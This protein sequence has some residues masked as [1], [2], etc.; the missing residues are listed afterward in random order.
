MPL[1]A[2]RRQ[3]TWGPNP[4]KRAEVGSG[5]ELCVCVYN[6]YSKWAE[7]MCMCV[8]RSVCCMCVCVSGCVYTLD[9]SAS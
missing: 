8:R 3:V 2:D 4:L 9:S 7:S 5:G 6:I 1:S